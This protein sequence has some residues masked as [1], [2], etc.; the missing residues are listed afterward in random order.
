MI[1][2]L[3]IFMLGA[4]ILF[5]IWYM[6]LSQFFKKQLNKLKGGYNG[7]EDLSRKGEESGRRERIRDGEKPISLQPLLPSRDE[8]PDTIKVDRDESTLK[9]ISRSRGKKKRANVRRGV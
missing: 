3:I 1:T 5:A 8:L 7:E 9:E 6:I 4:I 2:E